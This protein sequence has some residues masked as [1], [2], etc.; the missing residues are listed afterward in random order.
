MQPLKAIE[1]IRRASSTPWDQ[2]SSNTSSASNRRRAR[3]LSTACSQLPGGCNAT[4]RRRLTAQP[5]DPLYTSGAQWY[6]DR[7]GV[8]SAWSAGTGG[9][10]LPRAG[11]YKYLYC[12]RSGPASDTQTL[13]PCGWLKPE[14]RMLSCYDTGLLSAMAVGHQLTSLHDMLDAVCTQHHRTSSLPSLTLEWTSLTLT[15][16]RTC[17]PTLGRSQGMG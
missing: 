16:W 7:V 4:S 14:E 2:Y 5:N 15:W 8:S 1:Y 9:R 13:Q 10:C 11:T 6:M 3:R 17:G 12:T